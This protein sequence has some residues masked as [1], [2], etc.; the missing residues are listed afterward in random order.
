M[1]I[2]VP[3]EIKQQENRI[4][5]VPA[6]VH[7]LV[8]D[9]HTVLVE[10]DGGLG[11]GITN[12]QFQAAGAQIAADAREVY[13]QADMIVKVKEPLP[14]EYPL[15]RPGQILFTYFHFAASRLGIWVFWKL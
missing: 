5:A 11:A 10:K 6:M 8:G 4:G 12:E 9:G 14:D 7:A 1:I 15:I 13:G 2:G 3:K